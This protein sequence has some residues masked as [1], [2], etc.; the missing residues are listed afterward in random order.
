MNGKRREIPLTP[1][2]RELQWCYYSPF[3]FL[4]SSQTAPAPYVTVLTLMQDGSPS[5]KALDLEESYGKIE[6]CEQSRKRP[7]P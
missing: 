6:D 4:A 3:I 7:T 1:P 5:R 2:E